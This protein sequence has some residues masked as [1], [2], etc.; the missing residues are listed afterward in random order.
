[1]SKWPD[2]IQEDMWPFALRHAINF[3]N[4][5]IC[6]NQKDTPFELFTGQDAPWSLQ[7][8]RFFGCPTYVLDKDLQDGKSISKWWKRSWKG[9]YIGSSTC[10]SSNIPLIYNPVST[11]ISPQFHVIF[12]ESFHT[13][14]GDINTTQSS[15]F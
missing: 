12:D 5:S 1:M 6:K 14:T 7:D 9:V 13:A 15:Y 4:A 3:H 10:H 11:H 8:F 2:V